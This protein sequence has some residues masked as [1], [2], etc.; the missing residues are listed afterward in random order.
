ML[1]LKPWL[2]VLNESTGL[3]D[4]SHL[5]QGKRPLMHGNHDET[6]L[7][8]HDGNRFAW[9][10]NDGYHLKPKGDGATIMVSGISVPCHGW[11]GLEVLEPKTDGS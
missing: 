4:W 1:A 3:P 2:P 11:L 8:A 7:Y 10:S 6:I 9:V 5:P